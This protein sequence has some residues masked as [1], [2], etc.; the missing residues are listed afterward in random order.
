MPALPRAV[1]LLR[2]TAC[3][4]ACLAL[5]VA[6]ASLTR[7]QSADDEN[8]I[9]DPAH[10]HD[11]SYRMVGPYRGGRVTAVT[12]IPGK[13][14]TFLM[15]STGG[16]V[17]K[18][19]NAGQDWHN[20][21]DGF[22]D[23]AS[24]GAVRVAPSDPNVIYVGTGSAC[25]RGNTSTGRGVYRSTDSG[26][27]WDFMGLRDAGQIGRIAI[28]PKNEDVA[29]VAALGH[30]FGPNE[31]RGVF[32]T[33]D[34]GDS[35]EH[36]LSISDSTGVVDIAMDPS[37]PRVL[38]AGSWNGL[39]KPWTMVSGTTEGGIYKSTDGGDSWDKL[40]GGLPE[41]VVGKTAVTV[42][43]ANPDRVWALVEAHEPHGGLYRS[44]DGGDSWTQ[45]NTNRE[46]QQ[47]AW[48]YTHLYADPQDENT[49]YSLNVRFMKSVD[50]GK[51]F[52]AYGVPHGDV[53]DLWLNPDNP[54][55][56]VVGN[57]GGAQVS[58][59]GAETWSTYM[60]QPTAEMYSVTVDN[61]FPYRIYG[62]QQDNST[63]RLPAWSEGAVHPK[64]N[65]T[66]VGGCETGPVSLHPDH[67]R[68]VFAGCYGGNISRWNER[69]NQSRNVLVYPQLQLGQKP[70]DLRERFQWNSPI[71]VSPHDP[72]TVYHASHRVWKSTD[73]GTT[74][75]R[76]SDDLTTDTPAH[77]DFSGEP[78]TKDN[79][80]VE[81]FNTV[82][83]L[84]VSPHDAETLW[85]G[86]DDGRVWI[87]RNDGGAWTEITPDD[88]PQYGTVNRIDVSPHDPG[89]AYLAVQRYRLDDFAPYVYRTEDFGDSWTRLTDGENGIP[90]DSPVRVVREDPDRKGLLYAGTEFGLYVSVNDGRNWQPLQQ[91]LPVSPVTDLQVRHQ[92][93]IVATQGRS[94]WIL[95]NLTPLHQMTD[96]VAESDAYLFEPREAYLVASTRGGDAEG[97]AP[98]GRPT[99]AVIDIVL[100][101]VPDT[102]LTLDILT[103]QGERVWRYTSDAS[104]T[105][106]PGVSALPEAEE[107]HHRIVWNLRGPG[108]DAVDD[109]I[110]WGYTG[111]AKVTPGTYTVRLQVAG[112]AAQEQPLAVRKDPRAEDV[113]GADLQ[114]QHDL[115]TTVRDSLN[116]IYD[117]IRTI[118][119][120]R[121]QVH[122][123]ASHAEAAGHGSD[124]T[125]MAGDVGTA[126]TSIEEQL[127]QTQNESFQDP[128]NY[129]PML[130]NQ[131]ATLYGYVVGPTGAP[132]EG[133][134]TR[135]E[136]LNAQWAA[137]RA[138]L[139]EVLNT[140]VARFNTR[141]QALG[142][143]PVFVP[144]SMRE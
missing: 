122:S 19:T 99:G 85:A 35:W 119:S 39:R 115:A 28:H 1:R 41:G 13:P 128:L 130:D 126:L 140:E 72:E 50:G 52:E 12:G 38:Y 31:T 94:F 24:I 104:A 118:R 121:E 37:N 90:S 138:Q 16:G 110:V 54:D 101:E 83:S 120:V 57:D 60:N 7:A 63:I 86:T 143:A 93:L 23:V 55:L 29:Y 124:L 135:L 92:D 116:S 15:G 3:T 133:A 89:T 108:V 43:P 96:T 17:W 91:N 71:V 10:L 81:V 21:S 84:V 100:N 75:T 125:A 68:I 139:R 103:P 56:M 8:T 123:V 20:I 46:H 77:Q 47:R 25:L 9:V 14:H 53:H 2:W 73:R 137:H 105:D 33:T 142:T 36:V 80:G 62:P 132:T 109:A 45:I 88:L 82:F 129:P 58:L 26:K 40:G 69:T 59:D 111:G 44:D 61:H 70:E 127:V 22:F 65:W 97:R 64:A 18:T 136:D 34:G 76:I 49:V 134:Y 107:G 51:S 95:D 27:T 114:A 106:A 6:S 113:T 131:Y 87:T 78:I 32:R 48:Y 30:P 66:A 117:A 67:S 74:W 98:E 42:S 79:T 112:Q 11:M 144:T 4:L 5:L 141:V 102:T